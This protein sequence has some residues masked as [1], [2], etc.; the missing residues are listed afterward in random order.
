MFR[1]D[2]DNQGYKDLLKGTTSEKFLAKNKDYNDLANKME[3]L[4][5]NPL[6]RKEVSKKGLKE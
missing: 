5:K 6:L 2:F 1:Q 4:I 3:I